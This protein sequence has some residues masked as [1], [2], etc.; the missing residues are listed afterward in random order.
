M[1][2]ATA[3]ALSQ[4]L[5]RMVDHGPGP[6]DKGLAT[7]REL[8]AQ[9]ATGGNAYVQEKAG[10]VVENFELWFTLRRWERYGD[11]HEFTVRLLTAITKL[12]NAIR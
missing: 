6:N 5:R 2:S 12:E 11:S 7:V 1:D 10:W 8:V 4:Q 9:L 3:A